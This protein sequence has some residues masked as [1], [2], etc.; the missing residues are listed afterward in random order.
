MTSVS[1]GTNTFVEAVAPIVPK[2]S[3]ADPSLP[4]KEEQ[5]TQ[6]TN[7]PKG[8]ITNETVPKSEKKKRLVRKTN[9]TNP[10]KLKIW[11]AGH[12]VTVGFG[13]IS[14]LF[15][16]LFL[17]NFYYIN[18]ISYRLSLLGAVAA[19]TATFSHVF[20]LEYLPAFS[21]LVSHQNF[22]YLI[23]ASVWIFTF[24]SIFKII[25]YVLISL[26]QI[27]KHLNIEPV[28]K[29]KAL[30]ATVIAYDEL[31]LIA[32]LLLRTLFFRGSS[33]YQLTIFLVF[34]WLRILYNKETRVLFETIVERLDGKVSKIEN[35]KVQHV[36]TRTK[37]FLDAKEHDNHNA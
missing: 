25:P 20:G 18:T 8:P 17:P 12:A 31:V 6:G 32:Y 33:G 10:I 28:L 9:S 1:N 30:L 15:Q 3:S 4:A 26:L 13:V 19:L 29:E 37:Q 11:L 14:L 16:I 27:S 5:E 35:P 24:K 34:Y 22:Q 36:W 23:L 2:V 7:D 21:T